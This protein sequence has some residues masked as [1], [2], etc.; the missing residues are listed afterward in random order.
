MDRPF[1]HAD[2]C[3]L[4]LYS[5]FLVSI[6]VLRAYLLARYPVTVGLKVFNI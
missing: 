1:S 6:P 4:I 5:Y 2:P 3:F